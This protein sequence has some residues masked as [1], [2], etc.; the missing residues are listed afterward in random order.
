MPGD[1]GAV[2]K[3]LCL[4]VA[5]IALALGVLFGSGG[6]QAVC[7]VVLILFIGGAFLHSVFG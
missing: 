7:A 4:T 5:F 3:W 2:L 1:P 6:T